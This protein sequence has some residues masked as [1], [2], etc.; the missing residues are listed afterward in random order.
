MAGVSIFTSCAWLSFWDNPNSDME[1]SLEG[2]GYV[3]GG[4]TRASGLV[5]SFFNRE[6]RRNFGNNLFADKR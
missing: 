2:D 4:Q 1:F 5:Y 3:A 6:Y